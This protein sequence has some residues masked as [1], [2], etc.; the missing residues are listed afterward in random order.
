MKSYETGIVD[1]D[2][3]LDIQELQLK[4]QINKVESIRQYYIQSAIINYLSN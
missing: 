1:F 4:F 2:D 3:I